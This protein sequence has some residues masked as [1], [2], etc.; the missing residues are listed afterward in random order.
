[1]SA[2]RLAKSPCP[3]RHVY[4]T[5]VYVSLPF[6]VRQDKR[7]NGH[8]PLVSRERPRGLVG[9]GSWPKSG[10]GTA[11]FSHIKNRIPS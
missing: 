1:M 8:G 7:I 2:G 6:D 10:A 4:V 5:Y 9:V 11:G 3:L